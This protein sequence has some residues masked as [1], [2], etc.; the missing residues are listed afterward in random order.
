MIR[1]FTRIQLALEGNVRKKP[2]QQRSKEMVELLL[3]ATAS[4]LSK[5]GLDATTTNSSVA[6]ADVRGLLRERHLVWG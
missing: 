1:A 4:C 2:K 3:D 6:R 5:R